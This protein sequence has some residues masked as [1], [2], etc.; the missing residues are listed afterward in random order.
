MN[1]R[2]NRKIGRA[3]RRDRERREKMRRGRRRKIRKKKKTI[4][5]E[6]APLTLP[7]GL[8]GCRSPYTKNKREKERD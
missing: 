5:K 2:T 6:E 3:T 7:F 1:N 4:K 8:F